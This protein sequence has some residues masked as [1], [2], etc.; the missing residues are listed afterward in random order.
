M[1][2]QPSAGIIAHAEAALVAELRRVVEALPLV[3]LL[4]QAPERPATERNR[5]EAKPLPENYQGVRNHG[6]HKTWEHSD[7]TADSALNPSRPR[8]WL[9]RFERMRSEL[10]WLA[11]HAHELVGDP[12]D[13][14]PCG[15][16]IADDEKFVR[17]AQ[18]RSW[19][20]RCY[21][22]NRRGVELRGRANNVP[23]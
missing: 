23:L 13:I 17:K 18:G 20:D 5:V 1:S 10:S 16:P 3:E 4:E 14:C 21:R 22:R 8:V 7:P 9:D 12:I 6:N 15:D 11:A 19:H 2:R